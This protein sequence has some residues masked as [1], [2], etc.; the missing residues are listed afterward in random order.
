MKP[1]AVGKTLDRGETRRPRN[2][3][4]TR[5]TPPPVGGMRE[6]FDAGLAIKVPKGFDAS[7]EPQP[8]RNRTERLPEERAFSLQVRLWASSDLLREVVV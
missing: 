1:V 5:V 4:E 2:V 6:G 8:G 7:G 3:E